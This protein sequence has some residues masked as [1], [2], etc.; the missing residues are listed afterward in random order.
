MKTLICI[1]LLLSYLLSGCSGCSQTGHRVKDRFTT[2]RVT[3]NSRVTPTNRNII[4]MELENGVRYVW[5]EINGIKLRFVLDT[6]ASNI[7]ISSAEASV[8]IRQGTLDSGDFL[9]TGFFQ[10]ATGDITEG[11]IINLKTIKIG[12]KVLKNVEAVVFDNPNA[13]LLLGQT[14]LERFGT[15][16]IDN[17]KNQIELK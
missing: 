10:D 13:P 11:Q 15:I 17:K 12:S 3:T 5:I 1:V 8:L 4:D 7:V 16:S 14:A 6:G 9:R 2:E